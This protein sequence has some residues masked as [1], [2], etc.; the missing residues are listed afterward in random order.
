MS[1]LPLYSLPGTIY[2]A[3]DIHLGAHIPLTNQKFFQFLQQASSEADAL[4]LAGDIFNVWFGDDIAFNSH[5]TWL[6]QSLEALRTCAQYIPIYLVHGNRDFLI[7]EALCQS[8]GITLLPEQC[9]LH[10]E[11]GIIFLSH[12]DEL[13]LQ[14]KP[15]MRFRKVLRHTKLQRL[16]LSLPFSW[17]RAIANFLRHR[18]HARANL[19]T[20]TTHTTNTQKENTPHIYEYDVSPDALTQLITTYPKIDYIV[21]GHTH[22]QAVHNLLGTDGKQRFRYVLSDWDIDHCSS[23]HW[24]FLC[25]DHKGLSFKGG[26]NIISSIN[27]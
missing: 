21:H 3:S 6:Q 7:G 1:H 27:T 5:E 15:Y 11:A 10:T 17:R 9:L 25:I 23:S 20:Y 26:H 12:G 14:D 24:G 8:L 4:I 18:S 2:I 19:K 22:H 16:F 13:C